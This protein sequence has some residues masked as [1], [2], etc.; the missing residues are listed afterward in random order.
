MPV[1]WI[2]L[3]LG[4]QYEYYLV[5]FNLV[6]LLKTK[7]MVNEI[8]VIS[9]LILKGKRICMNVYEEI[10]LSECNMLDKNQAC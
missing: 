3:E 8:K 2:S 1:Y 9:D 5:K 7:S 6:C 10:L 4:M